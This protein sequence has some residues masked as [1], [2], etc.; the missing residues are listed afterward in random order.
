MA[1]KRELSGRVCNL[2]SLTFELRR[3]RRQSARPGGWM[4]TITRSRAWWFAVGPRLE[5]GV[6]HLA[7]YGSL[8]DLTVRLLASNV[9]CATD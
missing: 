2:R 1:A 3:G 5:R 4:I 8:Q 9:T 6:R 7:A